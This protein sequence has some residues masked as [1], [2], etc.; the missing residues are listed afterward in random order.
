[1]EAFAE[2][3]NFARCVK[4]AGNSQDPQIGA[5]VKWCNKKLGRE[6]EEE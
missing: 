1:V 4:E 3:G 6:E 5:R 2:L